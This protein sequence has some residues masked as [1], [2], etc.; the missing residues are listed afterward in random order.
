MTVLS[1]MGS[2]DQLLPNMNR[3]IPLSAVRNWYVYVMDTPRLSTVDGLPP[4]CRTVQGHALVVCLKS[5]GFPS[6]VG[7]RPGAVIRG[8]EVA[9]YVWG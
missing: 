8:G 6:T 1:V 2:D 3:M 4:T 7:P 9:T 5:S